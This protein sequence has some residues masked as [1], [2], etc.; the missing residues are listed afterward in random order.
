[1]LLR[2]YGLFVVCRC[3]IGTSEGLR[4]YVA[5]PVTRIPAY[6]GKESL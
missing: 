6:S 5:N 4:L 2:S 1:M 3:K